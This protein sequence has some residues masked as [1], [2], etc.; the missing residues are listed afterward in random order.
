MTFLQNILLNLG[1]IALGSIGGSAPT[2]FGNG[3]KETSLIIF[4]TSVTVFII[5]AVLVLIT[6]KM[7]S[8]INDGIER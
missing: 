6:R 4:W 8:D 1:F 2:A 5:C 3:S 7:K